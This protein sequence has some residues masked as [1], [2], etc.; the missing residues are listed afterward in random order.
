LA[1]LIGEVAISGWV[2]GQFV[3]LEYLRTTNVDEIFEAVCFEGG[4]GSGERPSNCKIKAGVMYLREAIRFGKVR[5]ATNEFQSRFGGPVVGIYEHAASA[6]SDSGGEHFVVGNNL[7]RANACNDAPTLNPGVG[8]HDIFNN[9]SLS[10]AVFTGAEIPL[11]L[12]G[13]EAFG[14]GDELGRCGNLLSWGVPDIFEFDLNGEPNFIFGHLEVVCFKSGD[15][16]PWA[17]SIPHVI[18]L[19]S[20]DSELG[21]HVSGIIPVSVSHRPHLTEE[22]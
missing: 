17:A 1:V 7:S 16:Y 22:K 11:F 14:E 10:F 5:N 19:A 18:Q 6:L 4:A 12:Q 8:K 21:T 2:N 15:G 3:A 13:K 9:F 20:H